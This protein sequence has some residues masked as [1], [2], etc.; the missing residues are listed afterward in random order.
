MAAA[1][2]LIDP[3]KALLTTATLAGPPRLLPVS[4]QARSVKNF[5]VWVP[6]MID[7]KMTKRAT[8]V[9]EMPVMEP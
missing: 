3:K 1:T 2:P 9:A 6:S 7:P 4:R 8:K 5:P